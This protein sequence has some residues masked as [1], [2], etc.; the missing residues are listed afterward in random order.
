VCAVPRQQIVYVMVSNHHD[1]KGLRRHRHL[2]HNWFRAR[3]TISSG[4]VEG[5]S[6]KAKLITRKAF[7]FRTPKDSPANGT[8]APVFRL[9]SDS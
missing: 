5:F 2:I 8:S 7:G 9:M 1:M 6:G 3:G 4:V